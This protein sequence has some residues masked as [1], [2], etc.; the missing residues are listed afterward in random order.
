[1]HA[2]YINRF[3]TEQF[4]NLFSDLLIA[5]HNLQIML[6]IFY[7]IFKLPSFTNILLLCIFLAD[8]V[9]FSMFIIIIQFS[10]QQVYCVDDHVTGYQF[11]YQ[12]KYAINVKHGRVRPARVQ[13]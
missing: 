11:L 10:I 9:C 7:L 6:F 8:Q 2:F 3:L 5:E 12:K 1:M 4:L 13:L